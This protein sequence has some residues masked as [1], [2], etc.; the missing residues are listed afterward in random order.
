MSE[1]PVKKFEKDTMP[2]QTSRPDESEWRQVE[3]GEGFYRMPRFRKVSESTPQRQAQAAS[4]GLEHQCLLDIDAPSPMTRNTH[5]ICTIGPVSRSVEKLEELIDAG[6]D[7]C[8]LNFSHGDHTYHA[9]TIRNIR[10]AIDNKRAKKTLFKPIAV[11]LDTKG[12]EI[13]TGLL[14]GGG[15]A[16]LNLVKGAKITLSL[17]DQDKESGDID[18]VWV[19]Y[20]NLPK[21][22]AKNDLIFI[23]DGLISLKVLEAN[24]QEVVCE[25]QNGGELGSKKGVNLPGIEVDLPAVSEKDQRDLK[26]G[27]EQ[28]V[29]MVFAS[30][31]R[32]AADV[33]A[34]RDALGDDGANIKI[35]SKIE[36]H[37]GVRKIDEVIVASDGIMVARGDMGIEIPAE[38]VF[39]AQKMIIGRCNVIGKPVICATQMLESMVSKPRPTR[40][41]V[42]DVANAVLDGADC[43]MLSGETA[44]GEY[45]TEA[46]SIMAKI[47]RDAE[48]ATFNQQYFDDLRSTTGITKDWSEVIGTAVVEAAFKC[49]A[50]CIIVLTRSG[51]SAQLI[52][53]YR[54][55]CPIYAITRF[56]QAARQCMLYR[57]I[58]PV[59]YAEDVAPQWDEDIDNRIKF[60]FKSAM[61]RGEIKSGGMAVVVTGWQPGSGNTNS[62]RIVKVP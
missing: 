50:S 35:I 7:I 49:N 13:R 33:M 15:S 62:M 45:P 2:K 44:K 51:A 26:F 56:E 42:S 8:R 29:D 31:I 40:A 48:G 20:K 30:F 27:V 21:V 25:I 19:D 36:N 53:K 58:H 43:V 1:A 16:V 6:M 10:Q 55:R 60:V 59:L 37:E 11:A 47:A 41:E 17:M 54:P 22:I 28:G 3:S 32:K 24:A 52:A 34:V 9:D 57:N 14:K 23:D 61:D 18:R 5:I 12:P 4:T 38:K 39:L 46:V